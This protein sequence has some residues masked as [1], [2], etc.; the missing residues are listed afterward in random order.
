MSLEVLVQSFKVVIDYTVPASND[1]PY[2]I[3]SHELCSDDA[4]A[5]DVANSKGKGNQKQEGQAKAKGVAEG[6]G[7][8]H[9]CEI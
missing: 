7:V 2:G 1:S 6:V 9:E 4:V 3:S 8:T 5:E